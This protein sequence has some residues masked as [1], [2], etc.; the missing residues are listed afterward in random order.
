MAPIKD[1][2]SASGP[3]A[4]GARAARARRPAPTARAGTP[5]THLAS[6][7]FISERAGRQRSRRAG[8]SRVG[9]LRS[10]L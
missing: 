3:F 10:L 7:V 4:G 9:R 2:A 8:G 6:P 5:E 1:I